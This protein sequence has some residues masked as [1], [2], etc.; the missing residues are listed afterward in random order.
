MSPVIVQGIGVV[1][2]IVAISAYQT[3]T[4]KS[5]LLL[6]MTASLLWSAHFFLLGAA[7]GS[8]LNLLSTVRTG[9]YLRVRPSRRNMWIMW[10]FAGLLALATV[11]TWHGLISLLPFMGSMFGVLGD[12]QKRPKYIRRLNFGSSPSW[13]V[14]N[15]I[16]GSY[17]G[18]AVEILKMSS[19]LIGQY[20]F[21]LKPA[22]RSRLMRLSRPV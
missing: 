12:W 16:S 19:N 13:L 14:Y 9:I 20:R 5:I 11:L 15:V 2:M 7:T 8:A 22:I 4:R 6:G 21:D 3:N 17:P 1:A 10:S 18:I